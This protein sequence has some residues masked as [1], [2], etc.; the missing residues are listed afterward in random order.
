MRDNFWLDSR[1]NAIWE[2]LFLDT[3]KANKV[4]IRFKG[5]SRNKFGHIKMMR[6]KSTEI[7]VNSLF[8]SSLV[9]EYIVDLTIAHELVHYMHG[10]HSPLP[11]QFSHPHKGG[12]VDKE[13]KKRGFL[14]MIRLE[15]KWVKEQWPNVYLQLHPG[16]RQKRVVRRVSL[17]NFFR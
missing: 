12:I 14:E 4:H 10:F 6:D 9:P 17:F 13:L 3:P 8:R 7:V 5:R 1:L 15:K 2:M 16:A 11:R